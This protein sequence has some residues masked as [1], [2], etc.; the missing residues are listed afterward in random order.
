[1]SPRFY[2]RKPA[3]VAG[4]IAGSLIACS[5]D[6]PTAIGDRPASGEPHADV[7][8]LAAPANDDFDNATVIT[9]LPF[10]DHVNTA[11][12]TTATDDPLGDESCGFDSIDGHTVWYQFT[13]DRNLRINANT[14]GDFDHNIFVYTGTR[15]NLTRIA[16]NFV[17]TSATFD[18]QAGV[19]YYLLLGS[20]GDEPGGDVVFTV[21]PSLEVAVTIDHVGKLDV[22]TGVVPIRGTTTCSRSAFV[23]VGSVIV[24]RVG[25]EQAAR[26]GHAVIGVVDL[27]F[28]DCEGMVPWEVEVAFDGR[29]L[30]GRA[31]IRA[32]GLFIDNTS[33]E[34]IQASDS[35]RAILKP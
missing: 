32:G 27:P 7:S 13:P 14:G 8:T 25:S 22:A 18:A 2:P 28:S 3:L 5:R 30:L 29:P 15:G 23:E 33:S 31:K 4:V 1:M 24:E 10:T 26:G 34:E 6:A 12:A 20:N 17:P 11:E 21:Q 19:T 16:C 35:T 9:A